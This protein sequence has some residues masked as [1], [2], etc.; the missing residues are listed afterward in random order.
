MIQVSYASR[1]D[2][3]MSTEQLMELL[4]QCQTNNR[5]RG[6]TG[7]LLYG[8]E[9]FLQA[10]EGEDDVVDGLVEH[11]HKDPRHADL[12]ILHR[13]EIE[14][15]EYADWTMG[16]KRVTDQAL[17]NIDG[18]ANFA[19]K[20]FHFDYLIGHKPV[21]NTLMHHYRQPHY[22]QLLGEIEAQDKVIEHLKG[23]LGQIS[24]RAQVAALA[25]E[26]VVDSCRDGG[27]PDASLLRLCTTALDSLRPH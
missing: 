2:G 23:A 18:L 5:K 20:D 24:E 15:R 8:N 14:Q 7:M 26:S 12:K 16:F 11:I 21:I 1:T 10:L 6:V 27:T 4:V 13:R 25:L 9:T 19:A 3:R 17:K 22:D